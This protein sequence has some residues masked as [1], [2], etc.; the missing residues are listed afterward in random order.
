MASRIR[1]LLL[2]NLLVWPWGAMIVMRLLRLLH[3]WKGFYYRLRHYPSVYVDKTTRVVGWKNISFQGN[4]VISA[5]SYLNINHRNTEEKSLIFGHNVYIG[6]GNF[7]STGKKITVRDYCI[8][9][10][11]CSFIGSGHV[12]SDPFSP[13]LTTGTTENQSIYIGVNC[14]I[15]HGASV[16]GNVRVGHGSVVGS[17]AVVR[18]DI[19]P[20]SV[21]VGNPARVVKRF[22][23]E[24]MNWV[25][26]DCFDPSSKYPDE[27]AYLE[28][29]AQKSPNIILPIS[30]ASSGMG[31]V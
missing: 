3:G 30:A 17:S 20:F 13:Y 25:S 24:R 10:T 28:R 14:F 22:D 5:M 4:A 11:N 7:F 23:F 31:D 26:N 21:V 6:R 1:A 18:S 15:G 27:E 16:I 12:V 29:L 9:A 19:P 8:T 2:K